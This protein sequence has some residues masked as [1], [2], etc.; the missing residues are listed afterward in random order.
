MNLTTAHSLWLAPLC[1]LLGIGCAWLLYRGV[2]APRLG[3]G[4]TVDLGHVA[5]V[6]HSCS[7]PF[8]C[9]S[10]LV[11]IRLREVR[12][13]VVV[14][15]HDGS[16]SLLATGDSAAFKAEYAE[17]LRKLTEELGDKYEVRRSLTAARFPRDSTSS[18]V[19]ATQ[20]STSCSAR[21]TTASLAR[22][23]ARW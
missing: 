18:R 19:K 1:L 4:R 3:F 11:R 17:R 23:W 2:G 14:V 9:W 20:T 6:G 16:S 8:S 22:T 12:K 15:A 7:S 5:C 13:P 10:P 21:C